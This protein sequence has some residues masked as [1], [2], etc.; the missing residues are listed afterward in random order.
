MPETT[1]A[2]GGIPGPA[3]EVQGATEVAALARGGSRGATI[4]TSRRIVATDVENGHD[5]RTEVGR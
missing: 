1:L 2:G 5:L 3:L 4:V